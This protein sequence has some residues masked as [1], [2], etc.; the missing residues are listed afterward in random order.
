[1]ITVSKFEKF[2]V[3]SEE[4]ELQF[5]YIAIRPSS[6]YL[7]LCEY[8]LDFE[9]L[10]AHA[11]INLNL[12]EDLSLENLREIYDR[13]LQFADYEKI[14]DCA[15]IDKSIIAILDNEYMK[16]GSDL[17]K[18]KWGRIGEYIF[19]IIL[20]SYLNLDCII[21][22]FALATSPNMSIF[23]IDTLHCSL[24]NR[25]LY[26]GES[27]IVNSLSDGIELIKK[28]LS[29][30]E[31]QISKE[32]FTITNK[33][34]KRSNEFDRLFAISLQKCLSFEELIAEMKL[35]AISIPIFIAH[36]GEQIT[37]TIVFEELRKITRKKLFSLD[38]EYI[39]ISFPIFDKDELREAFLEV[40]KEKIEE[41]KECL[42]H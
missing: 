19:N 5:H 20:D 1:M 39:V 18:D 27:K 15:V 31:A 14:I 8:L 40:L 7:E 32:Y 13:L 36:G 12:S 28:S 4:A 42:K 34:F 9:K 37:P 11:C 35:Q 41:C 21:R 10:R 3:Y 29:N 16:V 33:N 2:N 23:G 25:R 6:F 38:S 24:E 30:Y 22:K 17:R 26:F